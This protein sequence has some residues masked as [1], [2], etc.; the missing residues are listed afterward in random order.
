MREHYYQAH[1]KK[2]LYRCLKCGKEFA[3][4]SRKS[5]HKKSCPLKEQEDKFPDV[6]KDPNLEQLF[7]KGVLILEVDTG[8]DLVVLE[9]VQQPAEIATEQKVEPIDVEQ[10]TE[11]VVEEEKE[12]METDEKDENND[13]MQELLRLAAEAAKKPK[14]DT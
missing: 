6:P 8:N 9:T 11:K 7:V 13:N 14:L 4:K 1:L 5:D 10:E 12:K 3:N 2:P